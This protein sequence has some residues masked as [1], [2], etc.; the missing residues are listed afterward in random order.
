MLSGRENWNRRRQNDTKNN[1]NNCST[2]Y[3]FMRSTPNLSDGTDLTATAAVALLLALKERF[4][5]QPYRSG[6]SFIFYY[7]CCWR[8][9]TGIR[10]SFESRVAV[11][12]TRQARCHS[13]NH[14]SVL[15]LNFYI[16]SAIQQRQRDREESRNGEELSGTDVSGWDRKSL[17]FLSMLIYVPLPW[18]A[19]DW[20]QDWRIN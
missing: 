2:K 8:N 7:Q 20:L 16:S 18:N 17:S 14:S 5:Q 15:P 1:N 4:V 19:T 12:G 9:T 3:I 13:S 6:E 10:F 11:P